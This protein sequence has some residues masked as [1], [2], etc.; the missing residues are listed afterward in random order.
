M[1]PQGFVYLSDVD[2]TIKHDLRYFDREYNFVANRV[3]GYLA[4]RVIMTEQAANA[5]RDVQKRLTED[6][7]CLVVYDAYR[8]QQAVNHFIRWSEDVTDQVTKGWFY[9][10]IDK[11]KLFDLGYLGK[12]SGHS[13]GSTVDVSIIKKDQDLK[14]IAL[15]TR[16]LLDGSS[17]VFLDDN[18]VD[19]GTAFDL[20]HEA[21]HYDNNLISSEQKAAREY[22]KAIM[23]EHGFKPYSKEW[24]HFTL[25]NEPFPDTYFDFPII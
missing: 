3:E 8:P 23:V 17:I 6:G 2:S 13:R 20:L 22:L 18:S 24:W 19:M 11:A 1:L 21:S 5:L 15:E 10:N 7:Y 25:E 16:L 12:R 4:N 9:P 14:E